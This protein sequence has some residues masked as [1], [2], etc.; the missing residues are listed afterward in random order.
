MAVDLRN[1]A[2]ESTLTLSGVGDVTVARAIHAAAR[3]ALAAAPRAVV[4]RL[5]E[6]DTL[7]TSATQLLLAL[8]KS[9]AASGASLRIEGT[10]PAVAEL[11]RGAGLHDLLG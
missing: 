2:D 6:L 7:D 11:W 1:G 3:Q 10:P 4:V 8:R 5:H 9:L